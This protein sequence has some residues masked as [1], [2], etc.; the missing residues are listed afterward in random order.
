MESPQFLSGLLTGHEPAL[1]DFCCTCNK[2]QVTQLSRFMG[3]DLFLFELRT[4]HEPFLTPGRARLRQALES[5]ATGVVRARRSLALPMGEVHGEAF[6]RLACHKPDSLLWQVHL[7]PGQPCAVAESLAGVEPQ[8]HKTAPG[9]FT[10]RHRSHPSAKT[11]SL[12]DHV[13]GRGRRV[14][15]LWNNC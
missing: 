10:D 7:L 4:P 2:I 1:P 9:C 15:N 5:P 3:S 6:A 14:N 13:S 8:Q 11:T 12:P